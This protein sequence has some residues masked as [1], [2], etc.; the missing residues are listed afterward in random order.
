MMK[1]ESLTIEVQTIHL[2]RIHI[3]TVVVREGMDL[4]L[5]EVSASVEER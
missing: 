5:D 4:T 2:V 3:L 1:P